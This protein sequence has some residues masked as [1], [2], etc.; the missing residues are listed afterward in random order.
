MVN[1]TR[2]AVRA[3]VIENAKKSAQCEVSAYALQL[4]AL[5]RT[6]VWQ[7]GEKIFQNDVMFTICV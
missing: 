5:F 7:T 1:L 4:I 6:V 2:Q 3:G